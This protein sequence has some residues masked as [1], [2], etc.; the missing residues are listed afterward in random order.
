LAAI[1]N[2]VCSIIYIGF[3]KSAVKN[4]DIFDRT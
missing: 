1:R 2:G 3:D 4:V